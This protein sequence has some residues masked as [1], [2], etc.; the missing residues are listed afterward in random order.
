M[1]PATIEEVRTEQAIFTDLWNIYKRYAN[2]SADEEWE[3]FVNETGRLF[4]EKY[5]GSDKEKLFYDLLL[6]I[7]NQLDR[8]YKKKRQRDIKLK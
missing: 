3:M 2:I 1:K 6:T 4:T 8:N 7:T 5:K